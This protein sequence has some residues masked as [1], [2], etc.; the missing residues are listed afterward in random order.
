MSWTRTFPVVRSPNGARRWLPT[1]LVELF[2]IP[3]AGAEEAPGPAPAP[4]GLGPGAPRPN[5][6]GPP[7]LG[8][9]G[10]EP[11]G[12][13]PTAAGSAEATRRASDSRQDDSTATPPEAKERSAAST[14][15]TSLCKTFIE[16]FPFGSCKQGI[17]AATT[18][19]HNTKHCS[20][21]WR[22]APSSSVQRTH[23]RCACPTLSHAYRGGVLPNLPS[24][25]RC[26]CGRSACPK[27]DP[28]SPRRWKAP[29]RQ[30]SG[31]RRRPR[32]RP[33]ASARELPG[34]KGRRPSVTHPTAVCERTSGANAEAQHNT[35]L[36]RQRGAERQGHAGFRGHHENDIHLRGRVRH[37]HD[38]ADHLFLR[39]EVHRHDVVHLH[40]PTV[41]LEEIVCRSGTPRATVHL[42]HEANADGVV[43][44]HEKKRC[45]Q[46]LWGVPLCTANAIIG[47]AHI[48]EYL[49]GKSILCVCQLPVNGAEAL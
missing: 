17:A 47:W 27:C 36:A 1:P 42:E 19:R 43:S 30:S 31:S 40:E 35:T 2:P 25:C 33:G 4:G 16:S 37:V 48:G 46:C 41:V 5:A 32:H 23:G 26:C 39:V 14:S 10:P 21:A 20:R 18:P 24:R 34:R 28:P 22:D 6:P 11:A 49:R 44:V 12:G 9:D 38:P 8:S 15:S 29:Q 3:V 45:C 7:V 13:P